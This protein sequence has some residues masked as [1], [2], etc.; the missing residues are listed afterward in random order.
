[1]GEKTIGRIVLAMQEPGEAGTRIKVKVLSTTGCANTPPTIELVESTAAEL[2][3][4]IEL[5][6]VV[7]ATPEEA[8]EHRFHGSPTI[9]I[10]GLDIDPLM[11]ESPYFGF[12]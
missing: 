8:G 10:N 4:S 7:I 3:L 5:L 2:G 6:S 12:T 1:M 11:R 9:Q